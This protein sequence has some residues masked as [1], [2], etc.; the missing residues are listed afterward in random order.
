M[1]REQIMKRFPN[2]SESF[3]MANMDGVMPEALWERYVFHRNIHVAS[4]E[5]GICGETGRKILISSGKRLFNSDWTD[6]D[7][8]RLKAYYQNTPPELFQIAEIAKE[9][10]RTCDA[11][12]L[13]AGTL[14]VAHAFKDRPPLKKEARQRI[15]SKNKIHWSDHKLRK[16]ASESKKEW[17]RKNPHP[18]GFLG[19]THSVAARETISK[20]SSAWQQSMTAKERKRIAANRQAKTVSNGNTLAWRGKRGSWKAQWVEIDGKRFF[21]R[22]QWEV[23]YACFLEWQKRNGLISVW[24]YEPSVFWFPVKKGTTNYTPDFRIVFSDGKIE[25]HEVKGWMDSRSK[26]KIN[27]MRIHHPEITLRVISADWFR[28]NKSMLPLFRRVL[29]GSVISR[30]AHSK[31]EERTLI[32][33]S[34]L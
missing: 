29:E 16:A 15:A 9:L 20:K 23:D 25:F 34:P 17:F 5:F 3:I 6:L 10:D 12:S 19:K 4:A 1:T 33:I 26:T 11:I 22:S 13:M 14:G 2:A 24:E 21:A 27:R 8:E 31:A 7:K 18:R 28:D 30:K 32:E